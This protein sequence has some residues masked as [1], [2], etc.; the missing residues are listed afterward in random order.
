[1]T[2]AHL[3]SDLVPPLCRSRIPLG[4][5][6]GRHRYPGLL[7]SGRTGKLPLHSACAG[8]TMRRVVKYD[9]STSK[10]TISIVA[11]TSS[12]VLPTIHEAEEDEMVKRESKRRGRNRWERSRSLKAGSDQSGRRRSSAYQD[13]LAVVSF[14]LGLSSARKRS[15][16]RF[17][18][19]AA[20]GPLSKVGSLP[21]YE[22]ANAVK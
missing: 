1:M 5:P 10:I 21:L 6:M 18:R 9:P 22:T 13:A 16:G 4:S 2:K 15:A 12:G 11:K 7:G 8:R 19:E 3:Y 14:V 20:D 17:G